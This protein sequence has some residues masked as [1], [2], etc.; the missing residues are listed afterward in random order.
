MTV[1]YGDINPN[2]TFTKIFTIMIIILTISI[3]PQQT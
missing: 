1:G 3:V 2:N